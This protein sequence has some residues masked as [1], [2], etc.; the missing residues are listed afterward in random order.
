M[1]HCL[2]EVTWPPLVAHGGTVL[3][4]WLNF[5]ID[6]YSIGNLGVPQAGQVLTESPSV[7]DQRPQTLYPYPLPTP[8]LSRWLC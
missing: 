4:R 6:L 2:L 5:P 8:L 7:Y 3:C 1:N